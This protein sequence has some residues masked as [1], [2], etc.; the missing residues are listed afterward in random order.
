MSKEACSKI[1]TECLLPTVP[2][3]VCENPVLDPKLGTFLSK[4]SWN[5]RNGL[6]LALKAY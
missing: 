5:P 2:K 4:S 3:G 1:Q 6:E